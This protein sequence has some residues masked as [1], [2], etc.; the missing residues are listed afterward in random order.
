ML[1]DLHREKMIDSIEV[2]LVFHTSSLNFHARVLATDLFLE[3]A[4]EFEHLKLSL[5]LV[6]F[7]YLRCAAR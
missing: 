2:I 7:V 1:L 3:L 5:A 4:G 6:A